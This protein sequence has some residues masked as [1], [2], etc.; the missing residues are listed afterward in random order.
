MVN[1]SLLNIEVSKHDSRD[2]VLETINQSARYPKSLDYRQH[3]PRVWDQGADG[4]CSAYAAAAIKQW[5]EYKDYGL[6]ESLSKYFIYNIRP[7]YPQKGMTPR[8]T[9]K[10]L[11]KYG[12][13][14]AKS[15][16]KRKM[17]HKQDIPDWLWQEAANH[18]ILAYARVMTIEGLKE[19]LYKNGPAY[20][21]MPVYNDSSTFWKPSFGDV[22]M[23]GHALVVVG[24]NRKGFI[25][26][27]S[28]GSDWAD[29]GH[30]IYSYKD[31]G[32]HY[33]IWTAVDDPHSTKTI[34][35]AKK[36]RFNVRDLL[37]KIFNR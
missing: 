6:K 27:N 19:S 13:P 33:E 30:S 8:D 35:P 29:G 11:H 3:M 34:R 9:M 26:R 14:T 1:Q 22:I 16:N 2:V 36:R 24:Y 28:W 5:Q 32:C 21:A 31:F 25:L 4:P 20:I 18:R 17:K 10:L 37:S 7:N 23:G 15:Y 12:V